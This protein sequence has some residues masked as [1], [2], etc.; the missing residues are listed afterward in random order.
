MLD[1]LLVQDIITQYVENILNGA[2]NEESNYHIGYYHMLTPNEFQFT[3]RVGSKY[4]KTKF[5]PCMIEGWEGRWE[6]L[7]GIRYIELS[8]ILT[9]MVRLDK[10]RDVIFS[11]L[12]KFNQAT[13]GRYEEIDVFNTVTKESDVA[14]ISIGSGIARPL[15]GTM[16]WAGQRYLRVAIPFDMTFS[17]DVF[18]G[19]VVKNKL[20]GTLLTPVKRLYTRAS[21]PY[22]IQLLNGEGNSTKTKRNLNKENVWNSTL[23]FKWTSETDFLVNYLNDPDYD[24]NRLFSHELELKTATYTRDVNIVESSFS[25]DVGIGSD[26]TIT[27]MEAFKEK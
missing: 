18:Q 7:Q 23:T 21:D 22:P 5:I 4:V 17:F 2:S 6:P 19:N 24:Q 26:V 11:D 1:Y 14:Y 20:D 27:I 8:M 10:N 3:E 12:N 15:G 16:V 13:I 9:I 25:P